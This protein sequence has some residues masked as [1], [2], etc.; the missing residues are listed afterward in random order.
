[1]KQMRAAAV[2]R[3]DRRATGLSIAMAFQRRGMLQAFLDGYVA[4]TW[5]NKKVAKRDCSI[6]DISPKSEFER[7]KYDAGRRAATLPGVEVW[8]EISS[9]ER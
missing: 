9:G 4:P 8:M 3:C 1:M 2:V 6:M 7:G 5:K